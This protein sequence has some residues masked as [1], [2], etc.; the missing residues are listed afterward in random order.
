[1][2]G[3][4]NVY[5]LLK[6]TFSRHKYAFLSVSHHAANKVT[7]TEVYYQQVCH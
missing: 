6:C 3:L 4:W 1:M 2:L 7:F 5:L